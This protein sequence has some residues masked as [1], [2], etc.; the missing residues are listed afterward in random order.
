MQEIID[1]ADIAL[2]GA[3]ISDMVPVK[4]K[5]SLLLLTNYPNDWIITQPT[6]QKKHKFRIKKEC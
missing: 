3:A 4:E 5:I 2:A 6:I 1:H